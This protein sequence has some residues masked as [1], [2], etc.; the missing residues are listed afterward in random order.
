MRRVSY[1]SV[2][3][4]ASQLWLGQPAPGSDD[5]AQLNT[6]INF[7]ATPYWEYAYW[8]EITPAERRQFRPS[9][10]GVTTYAASTGTAAVEVYF[11]TSDKYYQSLV[12]ANLNNPPATGTDFTENSAFWAESKASYTGEDWATG[13]VEAVGDVRRNPADNRYYQCFNAHTAGATFDYTKF[14]ILTPFVRNIDFQQAGATVIGEVKD[15]W[16]RDPYVYGRGERST[17]PFDITDQGVIVRGVNTVVWVEFRKRVPV[18]TGPIYSATATYQLADQAY[19]PVSGDYYSS[20]IANN[21]G[22]PVSDG[23]KWSRIEFPYFL[24][25]AVPQ[26]AYADCLRIDGK[27]DQ[28]EAELG[29]ADG[30]IKREAV[31]LELKQGQARPLPV[32]TRD[33]LLK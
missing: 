20:L 11:A 31:K 27:T 2:L 32:R 30:M 19:D 1:Q 26:A 25:D 4:K 12:G 21:T 18:W 3:Q 9:W 29:I 33:N 28:Y 24:R 7:R 13:Q 17:L 6:L 5:A 10:D 14:C 15:V 23:T 8:P 16:D 22:N